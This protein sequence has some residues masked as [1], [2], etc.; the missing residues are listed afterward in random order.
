MWIPLSIF[1]SFIIALMILYL[2]YDNTPQIMFPLIINTIVGVLSLAYFTAYYKEHFASKFSNPKY[3]V[4][5]VVSLFVHILGYHIIKTCPNPAY[6]RVFIVLQ[7][8]L[9]YVATLY[10]TKDYE[11]SAQ[12]MTGIIC[13][14][15]A[16]IL[17]SLDKNNK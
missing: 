12:S 10:I 13:G 4:Y 3:Y 1:R 5:A 6:F 9:L 7:I 17:I 2:R 14:C 8:I 15:L 16:I 11:V